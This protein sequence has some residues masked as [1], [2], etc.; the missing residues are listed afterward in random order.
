[1]T[2]PLVPPTESGEC[3]IQLIDGSVQVADVYVNSQGAIHVKFKRAVQWIRW[4][5]DYISRWVPFD[6][7]AYLDAATKEGER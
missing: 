2:Q 7:A 4:S 5:S 3:I 1:M 6:P